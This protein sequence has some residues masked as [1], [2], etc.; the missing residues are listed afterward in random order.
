MIE[1]ADVHKDFLV[2]GQP[3]TALH[4][5]TTILRSICGWAG[6]FFKE[7]SEHMIT[8]CQKYDYQ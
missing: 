8:Q 4:G 1:F 3:I 5:V 6:L 2:N 7:D